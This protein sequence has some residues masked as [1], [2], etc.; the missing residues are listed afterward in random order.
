[1]PYFACPECGARTY[2]SYDHREQELVVCLSCKAP[3]ANPYFGQTLNP[4]ATTAKQ[5]NEDTESE[6]RSK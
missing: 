5:T 4:K 2:S 3:F 1:M 6:Q